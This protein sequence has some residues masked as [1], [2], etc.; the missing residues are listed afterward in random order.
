MLIDRRILTESHPVSDI[1]TVSES[2][3]E[4]VKI[5]MFL[6]G[7]APQSAMGSADAEP[8][9]PRGPCRDA[10]PDGR[11]LITDIPYAPL[12]WTAGG[13]EEITFPG[14]SLEDVSAVARSALKR[15]HQNIGHPPKKV[16]VRWLAQ[17]GT[18][19]ASLIGATALR[20]ESCLRVQK[21]AAPRVAAMVAA[22]RFG[23]RLIIDIFHLPIVTGQMFDYL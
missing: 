7:S 13:A 6:C 1:A 12:P 10:N 11:C 22:R 16:L 15:M 9:T 14:V 23:D 2:F 19:A 17:K 18:S 3:A 8:E 21:P 5:A 20:C 4:P